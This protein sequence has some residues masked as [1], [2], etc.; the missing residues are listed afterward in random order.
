MADDLLLPL[1]PEV[2]ARRHL[3]KKQKAQ[4]VLRQNGRCAGCGIKPRGWEFD[5]D[6]ALWKGET[7]Q[8]DLSTWVAYASRKECDCHKHKTAAE[9]AERAEMHRLRKATERHATVM[10]IKGTQT[11]AAVRREKLKARIAK[12]NRAIQGRNS[13]SDPPLIKTRRS[14]SP[15]RIMSAGIGGKRW[16]K[17]RKFMGSARFKKGQ[18]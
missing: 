13:F 3:S 10:H 2:E 18:A 4:V 7:K 12:G 6:K 14:E 5:H 8:E 17:G 9:A 11:L 15:G 16:G 1:Y